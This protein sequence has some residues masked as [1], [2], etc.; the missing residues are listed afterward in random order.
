VLDIPRRILEPLREDGAPPIKALFVYNHNPVAVHPQQRRM[1][2]ALLS[3]DVFVVGSDLSMTDSMACADLILP[4]SSHLEYADL[5]KAYGHRYLQ[6]SR[7]VLPPQGEGLANTE[8]F[9]RLAARFGF[10]EDC[11]RDSDEDLITQ[12]LP[13]QHAELAT[14]TGAGAVD[15]APYAEDSLLRGRC[16]ATPS[17]RIELYSESLQESCRAGLPAYKPLPAA[18]EFIL[19]TPASEARINS[20]F[21]GIDAQS[22]DVRCEIHPRDAARHGIGEGDPVVLVNDQAEVF[23]PA[24]LSDAVRRGTLYVPKGAWL[25]D[26]GDGTTVNALIPGHQED[27]I[28]GACYYDCAVDLRRAD[29]A[30]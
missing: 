4:A 22:G 14:L 17:G 18:R 7:A 2:E 20:T 30:G 24:T 16:P 29:H 26:R 27:L 25:A 28:G 15:M 19:V 10:T 11:F 23:L 3:P 21:G 12:A 13:S 9:R 8:L 6:R 5:Y 1:R